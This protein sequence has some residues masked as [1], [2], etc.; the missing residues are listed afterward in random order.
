ML[1]SIFSVFIYA[2]PYNKPAMVE[3]NINSK[4]PLKWTIPNINDDNT[5]DKY[6]PF[7]NDAKVFNSSLKIPP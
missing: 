2:I 4:P 6:L 5:N 3:T 7:L 1:D